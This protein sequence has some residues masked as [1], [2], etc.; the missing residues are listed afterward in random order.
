[1]VVYSTLTLSLTLYVSSE[2]NTLFTI[3]AF[4]LMMTISGCISLRVIGSVR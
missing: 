4:I 3:M 2:T 1:M